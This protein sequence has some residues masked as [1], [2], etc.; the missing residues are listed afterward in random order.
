MEQLSMQPAIALSEQMKYELL[1][2][3]SEY[4]TPEQDAEFKSQIEGVQQSIGMNDD[5]FLEATICELTNN[6][7]AESLAAELADTAGAP[8]HRRVLALMLDVRTRWNSSYLMLERYY[9]LMQYVNVI[10][11]QLRP[12]LILTSAEVQELESILIVLRPF[13]E[14]TT[15]LEGEKYSTLAAVTPLM[16]ILKKQMQ[17]DELF[18]RARSQFSDDLRAALI[19]NIDSRFLGD[20][21]KISYVQKCATLCHISY[22]NGAW[23]ASD[24]QLVFQDFK[25]AFIKALIDLHT[26]AHPVSVAA[27]SAASASTVADGGVGAI[28]NAQSGAGSGAAAI[29]PMPVSGLAGGRGR[30][31]DTLSFASAFMA[32]NMPVAGASDAS[33]ASNNL[34]AAIRSEVAHY[35]ATVQW[36]PPEKRDPTNSTKRVFSEPFKFWKENESKFRFIAPMAHRVLC[37]P[38]S[39]APSERVFSKLS[40]LINSLR[41]RMNTGLVTD[42][43][44]VAC[45]QRLFQLHDLSLEPDQL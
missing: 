11:G 44:F 20:L 43:M 8:I 23:D 7:N 38:A 10:L 9:K 45:N 37:A 5:E 26:P 40:H 1:S 39:E 42:C 25:E 18:A 31:G 17:T 2:L 22:F 12:D 41:N 4:L 21:T 35:I 29:D 19:T 24:G 36:Q 27:P 32:S 14:I 30:M 33:V 34:S 15:I 13:F 6:D 28:A 16:C 3:D